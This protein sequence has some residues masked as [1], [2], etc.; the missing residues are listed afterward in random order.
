[1]RLGVGIFLLAAGGIIAFGIR[2]TSSRVNLTVVG[3]VIMLA[4]AA[5]MWVSYRIA[6]QSGP[7]DAE[8]ID[9][10]V[11]EQYT[12]EPHEYQIDEHID[13]TPTT[14]Q[15]KDEHHHFKDG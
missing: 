11:E 14:Y 12:L 4:G 9:P 13:V 7:D 6:T 15:P 2:D 8:F 5:G 10:K 3:I 1:M